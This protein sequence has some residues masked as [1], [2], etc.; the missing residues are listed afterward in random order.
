MGFV[1]VGVEYFTQRKQFLG[2]FS[3]YSTA[4]VFAHGVGKTSVRFRLPRPR[5][6]PT[7]KQAFY[8]YSLIIKIKTA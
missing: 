5:K 1:I 8:V 4:V 2:L 6:K 7:V 3:G